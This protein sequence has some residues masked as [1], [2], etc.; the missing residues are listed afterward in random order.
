MLKDAYQ[1]YILEKEY[2]EDK[3]QLKLIDLL[4]Q[5][6][7]QIEKSKTLIDKLFNKNYSLKRGG[8]YLWGKVGRG[9]TLVL[10][11]FFENLQVKNKLKQHFYE[12]IVTRTADKKKV[13]R[14]SKSLL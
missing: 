3:N 4:T 2:K 8:V 10:N 9:K 7:L 12:F 1:K 6:S 11:L 5:F 13:V 14:D